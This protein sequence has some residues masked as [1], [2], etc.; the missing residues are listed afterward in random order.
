LYGLRIVD[1]SGSWVRG[2]R[3]IV[4]VEESDVVGHR[5][6]RAVVTVDD[7]TTFAPADVADPV[8]SGLA[9]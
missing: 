4:M 2:E 1:G 3:L 5:W 6:E 8:S 9:G 7:A